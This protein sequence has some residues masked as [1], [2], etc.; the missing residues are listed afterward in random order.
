M[1]DRNRG[2][3]GHFSYELGQ[4]FFPNYAIQKLRP[5]TLEEALQIRFKE[6]G[7]SLGDEVDEATMKELKKLGYTLEEI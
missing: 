3:T 1:I 7:Y 6:G 2:L 4:G 5:M